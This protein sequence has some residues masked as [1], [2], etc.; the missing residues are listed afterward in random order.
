MTD[1]LEQEIDACG[2]AFV[3]LALDLDTFVTASA[4]DTLLYLRGRREFNE[5][6][7]N[8]DPG[9]SRFI[10]DDY[11]R[12]VEQRGYELGVFNRILAEDN[13]APTYRLCKEKVVF[14]AE[15]MNN[16]QFKDRFLKVWNRW[17]FWVRLSGNGVITLI[18]R[19]DF[20]KK[21]PL[22][23][24]SRDVMGLQGHF[25]MDSARRKLAEFEAEPAN[26]ANQ[27]R[28][29]SI[30]QF[31]DWV[32]RHSMVDIEREFPA[33][34]WQ[35][36][37]EVVN[38][39]A[40]A[41][42]GALR[43]ESESLCFQLDLR[44]EPAHN[45]AGSLREK[46]VIFC[47]QEMARFDWDTRQRHILTPEEILCEPYL[48]VITGLLE[49]ILIQ[50]KSDFYYPHHNARA[51]QT[52]VERNVSSWQN[53][54]CI[55][56]DQSALIFPHMPKQSHEVVFSSQHIS[57][58][59]YWEC[60]L[61]ALEF[62]VESR[63]L[64]EIAKHM[65]SAYLAD[66]LVLLRHGH[67]VSRPALQDFEYKTANAAR[68]LSHLRAITAPHLIAQA[69]Y[70]VSKLKLFLQETGVP[71]VLHHADANL[72]H[73]SS[74]VERSHDINLQHESQRLNE[75][76]LGLSVIFGGL[77]FGLA[78]LALPSFI[79]DWEEEWKLQGFLSQRWYYPFLSHLG[80]ILVIC[81]AILGM[82]L[83]T[84]AT[85]DLVRRIR[86]RQQRIGHTEYPTKG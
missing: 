55:L 27:A 76:A 75:L 14:P 83:F 38:Q 44:S 79:V 47:F 54:I 61:R 46:Y 24:L 13:F 49:G 82:L 3:V 21:R 72:S 22:I 41:C 29:Q 7:Q 52:I 8:F 71:E 5:F 69:H 37:V 11:Y 15:L 50:G 56:T 30:V 66:A 20:A 36:A 25:D 4:R 60:I 74:L 73:L 42:G 84:V 59:K 77:T 86:R 70:S 78:I 26:P 80:E 35:M 10:R 33:V 2:A 58:G 68:L 85:V 40:D 39:F 28:I 12:T 51:L 62:A 43:L 18:A 64:V 63:L 31:M 32:K 6:L 65:T 34:M 53:E 1:R 67:S 17:D 45:G 23:L 9:D 57:Y 19:L 16:V 81:L 48:S